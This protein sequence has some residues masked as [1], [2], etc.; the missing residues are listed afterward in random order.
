MTIPLVWLG[1][2]TIIVFMW[3]LMSNRLSALVALIAVPVAMGLLGG[4]GSELGMYAIKGLKGVATTGS[5]MIFA[6][7][8]FCIMIAAG[9]FDPLVDKTVRFIKGDPVKLLVG[10]AILA[11]SVSLDGDSVTTYIIVC[12]ALVPI[13]KKWES[14]R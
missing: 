10:S 12:S 5:L 9:M 3:L 13:Y 1:Y 14:T 6:V 7:L 8:Y 2:L 11:L 4:M